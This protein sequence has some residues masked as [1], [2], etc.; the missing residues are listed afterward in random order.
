MKCVVH[1]VTAYHKR[2]RDKQEEQAYDYSK[3]CNNKDRLLVVFWDF[4][5]IVFHVFIIAHGMHKSRKIRTFVRIFF[6]KAQYVVLKLNY[7]V[8]YLRCKYFHV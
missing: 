3:Y 6:D 1:A 4:I 5:E 8:P 7:K 2:P